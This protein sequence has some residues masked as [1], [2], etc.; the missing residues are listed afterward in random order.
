MNYCLWL[1]VPVCA[2]VRQAVVWDRPGILSSHAVIE[3]SI[4]GSTEMSRFMAVSSPHSMDW[5]LALLFPLLL[6]LGDQLG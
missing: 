3:S 1:V 4:S 5:L 6:P 2:S